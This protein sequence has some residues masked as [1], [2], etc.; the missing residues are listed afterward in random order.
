[1][2]GLLNI[3]TSI[4]DWIWGLP[5]LFILVGG[6]LYITFRLGFFQFKY[7]GHI[8]G[9][10]FGNMFKK[11]EGEGTLTPFQAATAA[12][13]SSIGASNIVGVPV[14]I[15]LG[16]PGAIFWMWITALVGCA[17]K[18]TEITL[19]MK[20]R[21]KDE[22]G[23]YAGGPMYYLKHSP[24]PFFGGLFATM[25]MLEIAP[26][27]SVQTLT[28]VQNAELLHINKYVATGIFVF[29]VGLVVYG[30]IQKIGKFSEKLVPFMAAL[31]IVGAIVVIIANIGKVPAAFGMIFANAFTATSAIGGFT[32]AAV[33][34]G[35][36]NGVARGC[37]SNEAGMGTAPIAHAT[38]TVKIPAEQGLWGIFEIFVD[39]IIV[40][41]V[42]A[43]VVLV[44]GVWTTVDSKMAAQMPAIAFGTVLGDWFGSTLVSAA[45]LMFV[46][47]TVIV[48]I[49]YGEKQAYF[50]FG[51]K[52]SLVMRFVYMA[53]IVLGVIL[54]LGVLYKLLD[55]MLAL[56]VIPNMIGIVMMAGEANE[57]KNEYFNNPA[58]YP[59]AKK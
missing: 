36:R 44:S 29:V 13:A 55:F 30:G 1:M 51:K 38:A 48:I 50:L 12:L 45:L 54:D 37:Y 10:T 52:A 24:I 42:T 28:F 39:T 25:L 6:G 7:L 43:L 22:N 16:G 5:I 18:F 4:S 32:G 33:V 40:C 47:S 53:F 31:Y 57:M 8:L 41:T 11:A 49:F 14:A 46:L 23:E 19:G 20:Y 17:T 2:D 9:K 34:A 59:K 3:I 26:S 58:Y 27:V 21:V 56:V 35:I 15:A